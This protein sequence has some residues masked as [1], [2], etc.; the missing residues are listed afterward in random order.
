MD[1]PRAL[2]VALR[3]APLQLRPRCPVA[4][5][6]ATAVSPG[7]RADGGNAAARRP[8]HGP[9]RTSRRPRTASNFARRAPKPGKSRPYGPLAPPPL[10]GPRARRGPRGRMCRFF[11][12]GP[13]RQ[14][15]T[16]GT[17]GQRRWLFRPCGGL[18][19]RNRTLARRWALC[20]GADL[21]GGPLLAPAVP[22]PSWD[23]HH[24]S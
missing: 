13:E 18:A 4:P 22:I 2:S 11:S 24:N 19:A 16:S 9:A 3:R 8:G 14:S 1:F 23:H 12:R 6:V 5:P 17:S 10:P 20:G 7:M 21:A 15:W